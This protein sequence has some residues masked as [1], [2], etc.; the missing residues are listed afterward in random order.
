[1]APGKY[2]FHVIACNN[3]GVW[4]EVGA[5]AEFIVEPK[6]YQTIWFRVLLACAFAGLLWVLYLLRLR[7]ATAEVQKR[8]L[9]QMEE[10]ERIA[11]ELHDTLLQG[12]QGIAL[13]V[14]GVT[15]QM[16]KDDPLREMM[17]GVLDRADEVMLEGRQRVQGLRQRTTNEG[18]LSARLTNCGQKLADGHAAS[19]SLVVVGTP[20]LLDATVQEEAYRIAAEALINA[21]RH[22]SALRIE[23]EITY[24]ASE[25]RIGVRDDGVGID[26]AVLMNGHPGHWGLRGMRERAHA[27]RAKFRVWSREAAG[28]EVEVLI[29]A[30]VAY[31][32]KQKLSNKQQKLS[33][34]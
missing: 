21:F 33:S 19:F 12:F 16:P 31:P 11:R 32:P 7:Q 8:L 23:I 27:L 1:L 25:L 29:P 28:T 26:E 10:R 4:N 5:V 2:R 24:G 30:S 22:A 34:N 20:V 13:R 18:E 6:F 14:Q 9:A 17:E 3:S 15:K